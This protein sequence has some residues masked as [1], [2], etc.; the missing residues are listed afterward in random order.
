VLVP[1]STAM[2]AVWM[3]AGT[4]GNVPVVRVAAVEAAWTGAEPWVLAEL[5]AM[6]KPPAAANGAAT[7]TPAAS[8]VRP[9]IFFRP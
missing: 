7:R 2:A 8:T 1:G 3:P 5:D 4:A 6:A 9:R